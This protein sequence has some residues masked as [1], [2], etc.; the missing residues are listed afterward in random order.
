MDLGVGGYKKDYIDA[1]ED[2]VSILTW[3][4]RNRL[5]IKI[6]AVTVAAIFLFE[7]T[8][9]TGDSLFYRKKQSGLGK[10]L[11]SQQEYDQERRFSPSYIKRQQAKQG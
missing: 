6:V 7:Q 10:I 3:Y 2:D 11:P 5:F 9:I 4:N 8:G 1:N